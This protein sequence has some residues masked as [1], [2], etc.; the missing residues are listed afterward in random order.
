M[1]AEKNRRLFKELP[2]AVRYASTNRHYSVFFN[3]PR[4][5]GNAENE[6][7]AGQNLTKMSRIHKEINE[8]DLNSWNLLDPDD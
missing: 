6:S 2:R 7:N 4:N 1:G 3:L 8:Q 5:F